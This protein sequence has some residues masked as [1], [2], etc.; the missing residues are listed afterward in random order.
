MDKWREILNKRELPSID[1]NKK[2]QSIEILKQKTQNIEEEF[3]QLEVLKAKIELANKEIELLKQLQNEQI[4]Y[5]NHRISKLRKLQINNNKELLEKIE[6][7]NY[8]DKLTEINEN[9]LKSQ[10]EYTKMIEEINNKNKPEEKPSNIISFESLKKKRKANKKVFS[11]NEDIMS[12][13]LE[14]SSAYVIDL[15]S[16]SFGIMAN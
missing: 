6:A 4:T 7:I 2:R 13:E 5:V 9:I 1:E 3:N 16:E 12:D 10:E 11:I 14:N 15:N 8:D